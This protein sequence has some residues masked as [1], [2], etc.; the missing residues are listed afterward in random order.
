[1][2]AHD[3]DDDDKKATVSG[4][5]VFDEFDCPSCDANNP[6]DDGFRSG[7]EVRCFYCGLLFK[8]KVTDDGRLKFK[9]L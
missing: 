6:Y 5:K 7:D 4:G 8:V 2:S 3:F 1:M 9:E